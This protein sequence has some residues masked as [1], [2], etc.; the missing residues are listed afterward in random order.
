SRPMSDVDILVR[1]DRAR[2]SITALSDMGW[3]LMGRPPEDAAFDWLSRIELQDERGLVLDL[4]WDFLAD[5]VLP[6]RSRPPIDAAWAGSRPCPSRPDACG[7]TV[8]V[9][10]LAPEAQLL[11]TV[12]H[13]ARWDPIVRLQWVVD[14]SMILRVSSATFDWDAVITLASSA[15]RERLLA[16][17]LAYLTDRGF[18]RV[19]ATVCPTLRAA[20]RRRP[21]SDWLRGRPFPAVLGGMP[22][23]GAAYLDLRAQ[24]SHLEHVPV[25]AFLRAAWNLAPD[26]SLPAA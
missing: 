1:S 7:R 14:A 20:R 25:R 11:H 13:G 8:P 19:P 16:D 26:R 9:R 17:A 2:Q 12:V 4:H 21:A 24:A 3:T 6:G 15:G 23:L 10:A 22:L 5:Y 18:A